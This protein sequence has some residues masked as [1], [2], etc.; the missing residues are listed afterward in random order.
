MRRL[1]V[2]ASAALLLLVVALGTS[3]QATPDFSGT[4]TLVS[5]RTPDSSFGGDS[6]E[7]GFGMELIARQDAGSLVI[8]RTLGR[9]GPIVTE[10]YHLDGTD[11]RNRLPGRELVSTA[12]WED[13]ALVIVSQV[14]PQTGVPSR[15]TR[16]ERRVLRVEDDRLVVTSSSIEHRPGTVRTQRES[17]FVYRRKN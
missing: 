11:S 10:R 12:A 15:T 9:D 5:S 16:E 7:G 3:A 13:G 2:S 6:L 1:T 8:T 14:V 4:W 17:R